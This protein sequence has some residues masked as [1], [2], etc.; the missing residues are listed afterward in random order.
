V[1]TVTTLALLTQPVMA[2]R[3]SI[4]VDP[5]S[6]EGQFLDLVNLQSDES[7]KL[8]LLEQFTQRF[9][10]HQ[11]ISWA[12]EQLHLAAFQAG[13]WDRAL[14]FGE[15]L[16]QIN[17][18]D[19][20]AAQMNITAAESKGDPTTVKLWT[21]YMMRT[22][23]R[24]LESPPPKDPEALEEWKRRT[25]F[26]AQYAAHDEYAIYTKALH[27][28]DPR[29]QI[30]LLDELLKRNP[31]TAYLPQA[32]VIYLN[33]YRATGDGRNAL[34]IAER[35]LKIDPNSEDALMMV[36][37]G[38]LQHGASDRVLGYSAKLIQVMNTKKKPSIVR[39]E[40][41]DKKKLHYTGTA[42]WMI[43]NIYISQ[44]RFG[45]ADSALRA[46]LPMLRQSSQSSATILFYLGWANY[47]MENFTEAIR[48]YKQCMAIGGQYQE[49]AIKNLTVIR[50]EQGIQD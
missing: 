42:Y 18:N 8:S 47:K 29:V 28:G 5:D 50:N 45:Q 2:Q 32:L 6:K 15:R 40:D 38:S 20:D 39:Q 34:L 35:T 16:V 43:G 12:Y 17:P 1:L 48:F 13:Q 11:A 41:W 22:A 7:K 26:A 10:Q 21:D 36:A 44:S 37:E 3:Y 30:K 23:Q 33:A 27:S 46:A 49:Q 31:D 24:V 4:T 9:P 19:M 14:T 25:A